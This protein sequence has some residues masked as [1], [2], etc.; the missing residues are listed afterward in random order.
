MPSSWMKS[1][2]ANQRTKMRPMGSSCRYSY[3][4][5]RI[6]SSKF[7]DIEISVGLTG[8]LINARLDQILVY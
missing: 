8:H 1:M 5:K 2:T 6:W 3:S 7:Q 4:R